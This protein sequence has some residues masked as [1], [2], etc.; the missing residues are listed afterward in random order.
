[1]KK[2]MISALSLAFAL[3]LPARALA[4]DSQIICPQ[5]YGGGVVC[6][7][8]TPVNTGLGENLAVIGVALIVSSVIFSILSK[9]FNKISA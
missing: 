9:K 7:V 6:G 4:Q 3:A 5:P 8:H 1:M 2:V